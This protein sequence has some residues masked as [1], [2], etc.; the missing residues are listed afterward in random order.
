[1][2]GLLEVGG[3]TASQADAIS[4]NAHDISGRSMEVV[5]P[6][7]TAVVTLKHMI[8]DA[9][10]LPAICLRLL[11]GADVL[12]DSGLLGTY[13]DGMTALSVTVIVSMEEALH[14]LS[15]SD[16]AMRLAAVKAFAQVAPK[17]QRGSLAALAKLFHDPVPE[18]RSAAIEAFAGLMNSGDE[19]G[20]A[21]LQKNLADAQPELRL[22]TLRLLAEKM[23]ECGAKQRQEITYSFLEHLTDTDVRVSR[24][25]VA[26]LRQI[27]IEGDD[28][29]PKL[30]ELTKHK[31]ADVRIHVMACFAAL[32]E[33]GNEL[34]ITAAMRVL[35]DKDPRV[36]QQAGVT[37]E[38][39]IPDAAERALT[40]TLDRLTHG[41]LQER[42]A[43]VKTLFRS[44]QWG[45]KKVV[46]VLIELLEQQDKCL[47]IDILQLLAHRDVSSSCPMVAHLLV[48]VCGC[49][50]DSQTQVRGAALAVIARSRSGF[51]CSEAIAKVVPLLEH[52]DDSI[53]RDAKAALRQLVQDEEACKSYAAAAHVMQHQSKVGSVPSKGMGEE[54]AGRSGPTQQADWEALDILAQQRSMPD[55]YS[56]LSALL[57][58]A[59][60]GDMRARLQALKALAN[61]PAACSNL[62]ALHAVSSLLADPCV[63][64]RAE[65]IR[66]LPKV[67]SAVSDEQLCVSLLPLL[68][69]ESGDIRCIALRS[70]ATASHL[71]APRA[72]EAA[73]ALLTDRRPEVRSEASR[74]LNHLMA[75]DTRGEA[76]VLAID[77][78]E[79]AS[80]KLE[81]RRSTFQAGAA[82]ILRCSSSSNVGADSHSQLAQRR[83]AALQPV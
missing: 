51:S 69:S 70:L 74:T 38:A 67:S 77:T 34:A 62:E 78:I 15:H 61:D 52:R 53:R 13:A 60:S 4:I 3:A 81:A 20:V 50:A 23:P 33:P 54:A 25:V 66:T 76:L 83:M 30:A 75:G 6:P 5:V 12:K 48:A 59:Q 42:R 58:Y 55:G 43:A 9:W 37:M 65:A 24:A 56:A 79:A 47:R 72:I 29:L 57:Q 14:R 49:L 16:T 26:L 11:A 71:G 73:R 22:L 18:V 40:I 1:M 32:A 28:V 36:R 27:P 19:K 46:N 2:T 44:S 45:H 68:R 64:V 80:K 39:L 21:D 8:A 31:R 35:Q 63:E 17:G 82:H 41:R 7:V 10:H